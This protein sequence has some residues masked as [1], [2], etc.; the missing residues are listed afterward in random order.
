MLSEL[1]EYFDNAGGV[2]TR[3]DIKKFLGLSSEH[4]REL[5]IRRNRFEKVGQDLFRLSDR[6]LKQRIASFNG[7]IIRRPEQ[8]IELT[9]PHSTDFEV[10]LQQKLN[11]MQIQQNLVPRGKGISL[12]SDMTFSQDTY[13][14]RFISSNPH[15]E[16]LIWEV[17]FT[18]KD[19]TRKIK[20]FEGLGSW[21]AAHHYRSLVGIS[22]LYSKETA[23]EVEHVLA[24]RG[25]HKYEVVF[26]GTKP[27]VKAFV[28]KPLPKNVFRYALLPF[29]L[30]LS[31]VNIAEASKLG[32]KE[33]DEAVI[34][35][36]V[37]WTSVAVGGA[38][39]APSL[40]LGT[41]A[42]LC[43]GPF[44]PIAIPSIV[45]LSIAAGYASK[46][47]IELYHRALTSYQQEISSK[48][49]EVVDRRE[50]PCT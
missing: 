30:V 50:G 2:L 37:E 27:L 3:K 1:I 36:G 47:V 6:I 39:L 32:R 40:A 49:P 15:N 31:A 42:G 9:L 19:L 23:D 5:W 8:Y 46:P 11:F 7:G 18:P 20:Q 43:T 10:H 4:F 22:S 24:Q 26:E 48:L 13:P 33:L 16:K 34:Y 14:C 45:G 35:E 25:F 12:H 41:T 21:E 29:A 17:G 44:A 28:S 38:I